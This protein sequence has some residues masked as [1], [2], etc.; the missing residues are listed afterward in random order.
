MHAHTE[1]ASVRDI[2]SEFRRVTHL[3]H[4]ELSPERSAFATISQKCHPPN[5]SRADSWNAS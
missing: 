2:S 4:H 1:R 5:P 3:I